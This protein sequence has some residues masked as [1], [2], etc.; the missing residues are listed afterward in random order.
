[1]NYFSAHKRLVAGIIVVTFV[2]FTFSGTVAAQV[3]QTQQNPDITAVNPQQAQ[4]TDPVLNNLNNRANTSNSLYSDNPSLNSYTQVNNS[5][6][7]QSAN[8][9]GIPAT[10]AGGSGNAPTDFA[11]KMLMPWYW[12]QSAM[13]ILGNTILMFFGWA[14]GLVGLIFNLIIKITIVDLKKTVDSLGV[15]TDIWKVIRDFINLFFIFALLYAAVGTILGLDKVDWKKTI[16]NLILAALLINFSLFI[17]KAALDLS[18]IVT[19]GFYSQLPGVG[20]GDINPTNLNSS[21]G[22]GISNSIMQALKLETI[23]KPNYG[24]DAATT[25][26]GAAV[27][28]FTYILSTVMGSIFICVTIVVMIAACWLFLRRFIDILFLMIR[29]P[30]AFAGLVLPQLGEYQKNWWEDLQKNV[31]FPPVYMAMMWITFKILQ[32]PGFQ[33]I[34]PGTDGFGDAFKSLGPTTINIVFRFIIVIMMMVY[35]LKSAGKVGVEGG[36]VFTDY[37]KKK[38]GQLQGVVGRNTLGR[39]AAAARDSGWAKNI[40][41]ASPL[42]GRLLNSNL[43]NIASADFGGAKGGFDGAVKQ[44]EKNAKEG[45]SRMS[46]TVEWNQPKPYKRTFESTE[47]FAIR[48]ALYEKEKKE[49]EKKESD[50]KTKRQAA[51]AQAVGTGTPVLPDLNI[52]NVKTDI[53]TLDPKTW[54]VENLKNTKVTAA[55]NFQPY[56]VGESLKENVGAVAAIDKQ[57]KEDAKKD[58][59]KA[60]EGVAWEKGILA[61]M[62]NIGAEIKSSRNPSSSPELPEAH[63]ES[64]EEGRKWKTLQEE[65]SVGVDDELSKI[66]AM[67]DKAKKAEHLE[68][69]FRK[70]KEAREGLAEEEVVTL[71]KIS[72]ELRNPQLSKESKYLLQIQKRRIL[73]SQ[74]ARNELHKKLEKIEEKRENRDEKESEK[75]ERE[76]KEKE[77]GGGESKG[78]D[79]K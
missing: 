40:E 4:S 19:I 58:A 46:K 7:G 12:V 29:S 10:A 61:Y 24:S 20:A 15:I 22:G 44:S 76:G 60:E 56:R 57:I 35:A 48:E 51:Y 55:V 78:G 45:Y 66:G 52:A 47:A 5:A 18:N 77:G 11:W 71:E 28:S 31:I 68:K 64:T 23:Y 65:I 36:E 62:R 1:M 59:K 42:A 38:K 73:K 69:M 14:L 30:I 9:A 32:S 67:T 37:L 3:L 6:N 54:T 25:N 27:A 49:F 13:K 79:K 53:K 8:S 43:K 34:A 21:S 70:Y 17:T 72:D 75:K 74:K 16:G 39:A 63:D 2:L 26:N 50:D 33:T 41:A